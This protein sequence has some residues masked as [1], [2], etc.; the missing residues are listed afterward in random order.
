MHRCEK[1][2][3]C[4]V[5]I[6]SVKK[7]C[8]L[9]VNFRLTEIEAEKMGKSEEVV[10]QKLSKNFLIQFIPEREIIQLPTVKLISRVDSQGE[11]PTVL[12]LPGVEGVFKPLEFLTNSLKAHVVGVQYNYNK[13]ENNIEEIAHNT[14]PVRCI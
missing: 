2:N 5:T 3:I 10:S 11:A 4:K 9:L 1:L 13:S 14:L 12:V 7:C 6:F 8:N